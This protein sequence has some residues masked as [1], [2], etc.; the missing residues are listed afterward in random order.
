MALYEVDSGKLTK[1]TPTT[2][3]GEGVKERQELQRWL[4][5]EPGALGEKLFIVTEEYGDW[6]D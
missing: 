3:V 6:E 2:L 5:Q 1:I 4:L